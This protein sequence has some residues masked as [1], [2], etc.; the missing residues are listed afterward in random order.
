MLEPNPANDLIVTTFGI[1]GL[2]LILP[3]MILFYYRLLRSQKE[4][5]E[6]RKPLLLITALLF[7]GYASWILATVAAFTLETEFLN[8]NYVW[9]L[10]GIIPALFFTGAFWFLRVLVK[11]MKG[12]LSSD[13]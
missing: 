8:L 1:V 10:L 13:K 9:G 11:S 2:I 4:P 6:L 5:K 7:I 12:Q 3:G